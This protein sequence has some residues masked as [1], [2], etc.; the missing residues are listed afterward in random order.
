MA[1]NK[2]PHCGSSWNSSSVVSTCPFCGKSLTRAVSNKTMYT[3][4][5]RLLLDVRQEFGVEVFENV[6]K[7]KAILKDKPSQLQS[8]LKLFFRALD[9][10]AFAGATA[11]VGDSAYLPKLKK[12]RYVLMNEEFIGEDSADRVIEW[13]CTL[14]D[15]NPPVAGSNT[16][17]KADDRTE[18]IYYKSEVKHDYRETYGNF[19]DNSS[20]R[21]SSIQNQ[22]N[23]VT[24]NSYSQSTTKQATFMHEEKNE[25]TRPVEKSAKNK[26][27]KFAAVTFGIIGA[28]SI[29]C[30][31]YCFLVSIVEGLNGDWGLMDNTWEMCGIYAAVAAVCFI[32]LG[33]LGILGKKK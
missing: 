10:G 6:P 15:I 3:D 4:M 22:D 2:C 28:L 33:I 12:S 11:N 23:P 8:E 20:F 32:I 9:S 29:F 7:V 17:K 1:S 16:Y 19:G 26:V 30:I 21:Q 14:L 18:D 5:N 24:Q 25:N 27:R 13:Y 31:F